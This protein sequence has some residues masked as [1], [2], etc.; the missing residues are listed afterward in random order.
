MPENEQIEEM[1]RDI[2]KSYEPEGVC[3]ANLENDVCDCNCWNGTY[4]APRLY[5]KDYRKVERGEWKPIT[6]NLYGWR[7]SVCNQEVYSHRKSDVDRY[8]Y[9]FCPHCGADMRGNGNEDTERA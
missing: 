7:C 1:A 4:L 2:C 5:A 9:P 8:K 6:G 3:R